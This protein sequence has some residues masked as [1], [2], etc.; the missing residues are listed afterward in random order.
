MKEEDDNDPV[1]R[2]HENHLMH[3]SQEE[4]CGLPVR[5]AVGRSPDTSWS[6]ETAETKAM[7]A[8]VTLVEIWNRKNLQAATFT[9]RPHMAAFYGSGAVAH[10]D[11]VKCLLG[12]LSTATPIERPTLVPSPATPTISPMDVMV[13]TWIFCL[14]VTNERVP[15]DEEQYRGNPGS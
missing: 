1:N 15:E 10:E 11:T 8:V 6:D 5:F 7:M 4:K 13:S 2:L 12:Y 3:V 9:H 14:P